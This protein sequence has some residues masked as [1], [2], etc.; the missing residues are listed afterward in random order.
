MESSE[1]AM[2]RLELTEKLIVELNE[3]W[4]QKMRRTEQIRHERSVSTQPQTDHLSFIINDMNG[5]CPLRL[6]L[7]I[8]P[9]SFI[10]SSLTTS[11]DNYS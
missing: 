3:T 4:E 1:D 10:L 6:K 8:C 2:E 9:S 7:T 11:T 5:Q